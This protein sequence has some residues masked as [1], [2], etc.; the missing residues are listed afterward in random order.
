[1]W[2]R[3]MACY[4][5]IVCASASGPVERK[6][7]EIPPGQTL[8]GTINV[9][10][11]PDRAEWGYRETITGHLTIT[12]TGPSRVRLDRWWL[13]ELEVTDAG[14]DRP[15]TFHMLGFADD[16][17]GD[18]RY[19]YLAPA[20]VHTAQF[21][22]FTDRA[23]S[24]MHGFYLAPGSWQLRYP[25]HPHDNIAVSSD[26][27]KFTVRTAPGEYTGPRIIDV[28]GGGPNLALVREESV[29]DVVDGATGAHLGTKRLAGYVQGGSWTGFRL[30]FSNDGR[31]VAYCH[32]RAGHITIESVFGT[33]PAL[34]SIS[35]PDA[36]D[37]GLGGFSAA[38]F[39]T[40]GSRL[41][42]TTNYHLATMDLVTGKPERTI[43]LPE[44]WIEVSPNATGGAAFQERTL[45]TIGQRGADG[46]MVV[47]FDLADT[48]RTH[49]VIVLGR[50]ERPRLH[51][52]KAGVYVTDE[53][54]SSAAYLPYTSGKTREF[55][56]DAPCDFVGESADGSIV[57]LA[58]P[59][60]DQG[61]NTSPTTVAVYA[62][63]TGERLAT[64]PA[65]QSRAA[66]LLENPLRIVTI[67]R[68]IAGDSF[69]GAHW[70]SEHGKVFNAMTGAPIKDLD[71]T[72]PAAPAPALPEPA[73]APR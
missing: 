8:G 70:I 41:I 66:A 10:I 55:K 47:M 42:C 48:V 18:G 37:V 51:A 12:N 27:A 59:F 68:V 49:D 24:M 36:L 73:P 58:W 15:K 23:H 26:P 32:D 14:G 43:E 28:R 40:D 13:A 44:M 50:G 46:C 39:S 54:A 71:L 20:E 9:V 1:M 16:A 72:P 69:G 35:A 60:F 38:R 2:K 45:R 19:F 6:W 62:V 64:I 33:A 21:K 4:A 57:A 63:A 53:F 52:A 29:V 34:G 30:V 61:R 7:L 31:L 25:Q 3:L 11:E 65:D 17:D 5:G 22:V 56:T 67:P